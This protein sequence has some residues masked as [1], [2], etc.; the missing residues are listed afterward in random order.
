MNPTSRIPWQLKDPAYKFFRA[1][2]CNGNCKLKGDDWCKKPI[3]PHW[4]A[5]NNYCF[6]DPIL[7]EH[8]WNYG[9]CT[10]YGG[11]IVLDFDSADY[12]NSVRHVLPKTMTVKSAG[13]QLP[14]VYYRYRGEMMRKTAVHGPDGKTLVDIQA[15][16]V[17]VMCPGSL[18]GERSYEVRD[19]LPIAEITLQE[20]QNVFNCKFQS[21]RIHYGIKEVPGE[22]AFAEKLMDTFG[23]KRTQTLLFQCP[24]HPMTGQGNMG[25]MSNGMLHCFHCDQTWRNVFMFLHKVLDHQGVPKTERQGLWDLEVAH[26]YEQKRMEEG[27]L[28]QTTTEQ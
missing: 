8:P 28:C 23:I 22:K 27:E 7:L 17:G 21:P 26:N 25:A 9:V 13:R 3:D 24:F 5:T 12:F 14:H 20:L 15:A 6:N 11:L 18:V 1:G 19:D 10:G 4:N 16:R 2:R